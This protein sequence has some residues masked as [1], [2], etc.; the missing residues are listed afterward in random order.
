MEYDFIKAIEEVIEDCCK[1]FGSGRVVRVQRKDKNGNITLW[2]EAE[3]VEHPN[4]THDVIELYICYNDTGNVVYSRY[5]E[6]TMTK[7]RIT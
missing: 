1:T 2:L 7:K 3:W 6:E 5:I 4:G